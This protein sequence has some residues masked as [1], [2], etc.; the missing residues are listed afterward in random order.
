MCYH[1]FNNV[2]FNSTV[3]KA[4]GGPNGGPEIIESKVCRY[5]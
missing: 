3:L 1:M 4:I 2:Q 5:D